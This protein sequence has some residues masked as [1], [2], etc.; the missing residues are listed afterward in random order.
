MKTINLKLML[1]HRGTRTH[2]IT[3]IEPIGHM[4]LAEMMASK[5]IE[6]AVF[7]GE[8]L[9]GLEFLAATGSDGNTVVGL[10][11]DYENQ[12]AVESFSREIKR[13]YGA[14]VLVGGPQTVGL[15]EDFL[16][17][18]QADAIMR[19]EG[20]YSLFEAIHAL[21]N[22]AIEKWES[23]PGLCSLRS[24][25]SYYDNGIYPA[26]ENLDALPII[27]GT[28]KSAQHQGINHMAVMSG[29]GCPFHCSFCY[30]GG[31]SKNVR[32]RSV[33]NVMQEIRCRLKQNPNVKYIFFGDDTFTLDK[34]RVRSF[35]EQ[36]KE[37][38]KEHDFVWF[39]DAHVNIVIK[40]P[41]IVKMMVDAGL[42]R[43]Q[44]G[45]ESC[46]QHIIDIYNKKIKR[47]GLFEVIEIC[48]AAGLPQLVGNIIIGGALETRES[49]DY[50]FDT[51]NQMIKAGRGMV[52]VVSTFYM[53]F[54]ETAMSK[55]PQAFGIYVKDEGALT[56][57]GDFP[58]IETATLS[59]EEICAARNEFFEMNTRLMRKML[60]DGEIPDE[61]ILKS[62]A[63]SEKYGLSGMWQGLAYSRYPYFDAQYK[64][65]IRGDKLTKDYDEE[66]VFATH[67]QRIALLSL[68]PELAAEI[69]VLNGFVYSPFEFEVLKYSSGKV[70]MLEMAEILFP[71]YQ[72]SFEN[73]EAFKEHLLQTIKKLEQVGMCVLSG[74][75][76]AQTT[77]QQW[78]VRETTG[79]NIVKNK[80]ILFKLSTIGMEI[81]G[82]SRNGAFLGIYGL[83][84]Y[85]DANGYDAIVCECRPD[86]TI[87]YLKRYPFHE[88]CGIGFSVDFE[89]K[90]V[91]RKVSA[92][93]TE[94]YRI[95]VLIGGPEAISL[96]EDYLRQ[97]Q[98]TAIVRGEGEL[99]MVAVL[100]AIKAQQ[101]LDKIP[102]IFYLNESGQAI[103][104]GEGPV[105]E[106][107]DELPFPAYDKSITPIDFSSL[108]LM[109]SRG[110]PYHCVFCHE[111]ALKR[112][113]RQRSVANV[114]A[115]MKY[116]LQKYPELSYFKFCDDTLVTNPQWLDAFCREAK[117]LQ[118]IRPFQFYCEADVVSLSRRPEVLK[119]MVDAGLNRLQIG[120]ETVDKEMLKVY[121]KNISPEMVETVVKAAYDAGVQ[122]VFGALLVGGPFENREHI[123]KN[124]AFGAKLLRLGPGM[125]EI[126]PSIVMPYPMTDI[127]LH[128]EKYGLT[129]YDR[130]GL[131]SI[132]DYPMMDSETMDRREIMGAY[133][134]YLQSFVDEVKIML[135]D[136]ELTHEDI[137][138]CYQTALAVNGPKYWIN[139]ISHH[140]PTLTA[141][142]TMLAREAASRIVD[143]DRQ[144]L[145]HWR[146]QR[147]IEM[148]R[149][150]DFSQGYP[151]LWGEALS[152]FEYEIMKYATGKSTIATMTE[153][154]YERFG[155]P[156][157][158]GQDELMERIIETLK[159]FDKKYWLLVVPF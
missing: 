61:V 76:T 90:H 55:N 15:G 45:I 38:R 92:A 85:L 122:Q 58:V 37:L 123:E 87:D 53:P 1:I 17:A 147:L 14:T 102:G 60:S 149:D 158:E 153:L 11:C 110:C 48:Q 133:Q 84:S 68:T 144:E 111:G 119:A 63:L 32:R 86:Q 99:A 127:G 21:Q 71:A 130:Q 106:N 145:P 78:Q 105:V 74:A 98:A 39:A 141:Y 100:E 26:I 128:P 24:D 5:G 112:P 75:L 93:I 31:N 13:R 88:I 117:A 142:Y 156:F 49:L 95:P 69:P 25:G 89:N 57:V 10:Y 159:V 126:A 120:I 146:P 151:L 116:F 108:Y 16:R 82:F 134:E 129:I 20:E 51:V 109:S 35:C 73:F 114:I 4:S 18:S 150:V 104:M 42:V 96:D 139:I 29:R 81:A 136:G 52:E 79:E 101:S 83:A 22:E 62:Y 125:M 124:K 103:D 65:R 30:E 138:R 97:S 154:L 40:Y 107:L 64:A 6:V 66:T 143:V 3:Q 72:H 19:G 7:S 152:P 33:A 132:S 140:K 157:G 12:S 77:D 91:V 115:E 135:N 56:S 41:E 36:L 34:E 70:S 59:I 131:S 2:S 50:T 137:L 23:I 43:M 155:K 8:L 46:N 44:I 28:I 148:W 121:R 113:M 94:T 54:P 27:T 80:F 9:K 47:E 118:A 67:P